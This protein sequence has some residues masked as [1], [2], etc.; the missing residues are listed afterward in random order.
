LATW[1]SD[2]KRS[3]QL[4][5]QFGHASQLIGQFGHATASALA[6][7]CIAGHNIIMVVQKVRLANQI[8]AVHDLVGQF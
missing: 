5:G 8:S 4:I 7:K 3:S 6:C 2:S 1:T